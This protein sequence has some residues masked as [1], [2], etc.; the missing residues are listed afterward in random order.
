MAPPPVSGTDLPTREGT[1]SLSFIASARLLSMFVLSLNRMLRALCHAFL[2]PQLIEEKKL[3]ERKFGVKITLG[4]VGWGSCHG[5]T[6]ID[7][8]A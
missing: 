5:Q 8:I 7:D 2:R 3:G 6:P 4:G 1:D